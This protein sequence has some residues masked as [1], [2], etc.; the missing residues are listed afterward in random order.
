M[1]GVSRKK[2]GLGDSFS[3]RAS[4]KTTQQAF[5]V[6]LTIKSGKG[7]V[8]T[9]LNGLSDPY[10]IVKGAK[11]AIK[12]Q[13]RTSTRGSPRDLLLS[14]VLMYT[15]VYVYLRMFTDQGSIRHLATR[16]E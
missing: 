13:V 7:L 3:E 16:L 5:E 12:L 6:Q 11:G 10:C 14:F 4:T 8:A 15:C 1:T 2:S 9:D